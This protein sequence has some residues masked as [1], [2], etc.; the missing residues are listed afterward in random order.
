MSDLSDEV[1]S[2]HSGEQGEVAFG[3]QGGLTRRGFLTR[4]A[5]TAATV[6]AVGSLAGAA[7][8]TGKT[9]AVRKVPGSGKKVPLPSAAEVRADYQRMVD[10][11]PRLPGYEEHL[12]FCDW[13]EDEFVKAGLELL[14]TD[15]IP[16]RRWRPGATSLEIGG[17]TYD[18]A[19]TY[20]RVPGTP[21]GGI[22]APLILEGDG[23]VDGKIVL[24]E[25][26]V[27]TPRKAGLFIAM[28]DYWQW[29]GHTAFEGAA[30]EFDRFA[31]T[32]WP[33]I[34]PYAEQGA[35][36]VIFISRAPR[37]EVEGNWSPHQGAVQPIP[38]LV[39]DRDMGAELK[40]L[41]ASQP[42]ATLKL[43]A[44]WKD[45]YVPQITGILPGESDDV[46]VINSHTDGQ[47]AFEENGAVALV[48]MARHFASLSG[49]EKLKRTLVFLAWPG[50]MAIPSNRPDDRDTLPEQ[51]GWFTSHRDLFE[52]TVAAVT[53][54]HL[55]ATRWA[56]D[57]EK[58][59]HAT[60]DSDFYAIWTTLGAMQDLCK[61]ALKK[62]DLQRH[63]LLRPPVQV[64]PGVAWHHRG[65]PHV[66]GI[67]APKYLVRVS[68]NGDIDKLDPKLAARQTAFYADVVKMLDTADPQAL[69]AGGE[70]D[71][72][73]N[74]VS[75]RHYPM[76]RARSG[77]A[78]KVVFDAGSGR[79]LAV[80]IGGRAARDRD[81]GIQIAALD[82]PLGKVTVAVYRDDTLLGK[83]KPVR[84]ERKVKRIAVHR[85][86]H[87]ADHR[88]LHRNR[89]AAKF[90]DGTYT[91][92]VRQDG[93]LLGQR[94]V[95]FRRQR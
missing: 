90:R 46:I 93:K 39:L 13:I 40:A 29:R 68:E 59:Y 82:R 88:N 91:I 51:F 85:R 75:D 15:Q 53:I 42:N 94:N 36:A 71:E 6:G 44:S 67:S 24:V 56:D 79:R 17:K 83:S 9:K 16:Y 5:A 72:S 4:S 45:T 78:R 65:V 69:L 50:H 80:Y 3:G 43:E 89:S 52:R 76:T 14:P 66:A 77:P 73:F 95:T 18:P 10:F 27:P 25:A 55:G 86:G 92:V 60:G 20:V 35:E 32:D 47:N 21:P 22:T 57:P 54:E 37:E 62:S 7:S 41:A 81:I 74:S 70:G 87:R 1:R 28:S 61:V 64:T 2:E 49:K 48:H 63:A 19:T 23:P 38:G 12:E 34:K 11:G 31:F 58:G 30:E 84:A 8:A 33:S 26:N